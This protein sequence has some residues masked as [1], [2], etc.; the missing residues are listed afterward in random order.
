MFSPRLLRGSE[1][2]Y[3]PPSTRR[4]LSWRVRLVSHLVHCD[5]EL[6]PFEGAIGRSLEPSLTWCPSK[7]RIVISRVRRSGSTFSPRSHH[8]CCPAPSLGPHGNGFS[9]PPLYPGVRHMRNPPS[10][11]TRSLQRTNASPGIAAVAPL[12]SPGPVFGAVQSRNLHTP[13]LLVTRQRRLGPRPV[14]EQSLLV[15]YYVYTA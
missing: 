10:S 12:V 4:Q 13:H 14:S 2:T 1:L 5:P 6:G 15:F 3:T 9:R 8:P 11:P 7:D